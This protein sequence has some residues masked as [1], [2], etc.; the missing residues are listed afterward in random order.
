MEPVNQITETKTVKEAR[1]SFENNVYA[2]SSDQK[3]GYI[4]G[5]VDGMIAGLKR[6]FKEQI[7]AEAP[8]LL[9]Q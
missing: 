3:L 6:E 1:E 2:L 5:Y 9:R 7:A 8:T 4:C